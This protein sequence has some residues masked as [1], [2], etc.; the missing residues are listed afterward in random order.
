MSESAVL[1]VTVTLF[2]FSV[3]GSLGPSLAARMPPP[4][5]LA[6]LP[7]RVT[8]VNVAWPPL[9]PSAPASVW[10]TLLASVL[11]DSVSVQAIAD[12]HRGAAPT[13]NPEA[14]GAA[15]VESFTVIYDR[16]GA[17]LE[18]LDFA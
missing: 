8:L 3:A 2:K 6:V 11:S 18:T 5:R 14:A 1:P 4:S 16:N 13:F 15:K 7:L 10:D 17:A 9:M 12:K